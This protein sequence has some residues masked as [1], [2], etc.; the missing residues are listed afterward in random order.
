MIAKGR[1]ENLPPCLAQCTGQPAFG[2]EESKDEMIAELSKD[3]GDF[4]KL[5]QDIHNATNA[6]RKRLDIKE[7]QL[8]EGSRLKCRTFYAA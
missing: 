3:A 5:A 1:A 6:V 2:E 8:D 7:E 4:E